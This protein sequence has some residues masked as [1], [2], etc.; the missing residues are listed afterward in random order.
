M[1]YL[2]SLLTIALGGWLC[3]SPGAFDMMFGVAFVVI[4]GNF[5][6]VAVDADV[7]NRR[8]K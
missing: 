8:D 2:I 3:T 4:G 6:A 1:T 7:R 5:L